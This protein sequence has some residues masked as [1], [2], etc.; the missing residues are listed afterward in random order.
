[1]V[2]ARVHSGFSLIEF[3]IVLV[4]FGIAIALGIPSFSA[5]L[6]NS[7]IRTA[8]ETLLAGVQLS[9]VQAVTMNSPVCLQLLDAAGALAT[10]GTNWTVI[11]PPGLD[12]T[13]A[14]T[15]TVI[16]SK[17]A[18]EGTR[19]VV[20]NGNGATAIAFN[21]LGGV[22][23]PADVAIDVTNPTG[24]ACVAAGGNMRCLQIRVTR[25]GQVRMCDPA[26]ATVGDPR[27]C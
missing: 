5:W 23:P 7:Q 13:T 26:V 19:N 12:C 6:Q 11:G 1:M 15:G 17:P 3:G 14:S 9:R 10:T 8:G 4:I 22:S 18:A 2:G 27:K 25:A 16:Q 21:G 20:I 24:G